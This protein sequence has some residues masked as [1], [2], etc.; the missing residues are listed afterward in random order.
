MWLCPSSLM[1]PGYG[2]VLGV[3][4]ADPDCG[5]DPRLADL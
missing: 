4:S 1:H 2:G 3:G 5:F